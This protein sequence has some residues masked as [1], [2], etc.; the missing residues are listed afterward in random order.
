MHNEEAAVKGYHQIAPCAEFESETMQC[1]VCGSQVG[2]LR[3]GN[4]GATAMSWTPL[5]VQ[6]AGTPI[7]DTTRSQGTNQ[8]WRR[9]DRHN[10]AFRQNN[11]ANWQSDRHIWFLVR[12]DCVNVIR[13]RQPCC[14]Y[15]LQHRMRTGFGG[16]YQWMKY[17][18]SGR[19]L[20]GEADGL[21]YDDAEFPF[22]HS[23]GAAASD[24]RADQPAP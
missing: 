1:Q 12:E 3:T 20:Q 15:R 6:C 14:K 17:R 13:C 5:R 23:A 21:P 8:A 24:E 18:C 11:L 7:T 9:R 16:N 4:T 10:A 2:A 22:D 19:P